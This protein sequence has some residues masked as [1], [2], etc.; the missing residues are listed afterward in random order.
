MRQFND[1]F[2]NYF[3]HDATSKLFYDIRKHHTTCIVKVPFMFESDV[4]S[5]KTRM[6]GMST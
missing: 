1:N 5:I 4:Y 6:C 2:D 3:R